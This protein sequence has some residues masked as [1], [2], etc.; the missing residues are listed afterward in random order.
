MSLELE[1][2]L[3]LQLDVEEF[4]RLPRKGEVV[5]LFPTILSIFSPQGPEVLQYFLLNFLRTLLW[6]QSLLQET[7]FASTQFPGSPQLPG[8][9]TPRG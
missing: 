6:R 5:Q 2:C 4:P 7:F 3:P 9:D 1:T 8:T